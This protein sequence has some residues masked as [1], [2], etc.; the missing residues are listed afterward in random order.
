MVG[1]PPAAED[2]TARARIRDAALEQFAAHG[3]RGTTIRGVAE[4][5]GVSPGLVQHHFGSK[6]RLREACDDHVMAEIRRIK[7]EALDNGSTDPGYLSAAVQAGVPLRRYLARA[8]VDGS[9]GAA[10]LFDETVQFTKEM[11]ESP[12]PGLS[13]PTTSDLHAYAVAM[14]SMSF[15]VIALHEHLTRALGVDTLSAEGYPRL[16]RAL[17]EVFTDN[18]LSPELVEQS[19][20]A[21]DQ[22]PGAR[23]GP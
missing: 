16:T 6:Q 14:A 9:P 5:A 4:A 13:K 20:A 10:R 19:L 3:V 2:L 23:G 17:I 8:L 18:L 11:M 7:M 12:P 15:G 21:M 22:M 1:P